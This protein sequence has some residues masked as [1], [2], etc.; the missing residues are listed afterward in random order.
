MK[1]NRIKIFFAAAATVLAVLSCQ[2][3]SEYQPAEPEADNWGIYFPTQENTGSH[4]YDP[5]ME[6]STSFTVARKKSNG[7]VTVP[8]KVTV[9]EDGIFQFGDIVF[10]DG[11]TET[12]LDVS[13]SGAPEGKEV[14]FSLEVVNEGD[15]NYTSVYGSG[16]TGISF[17]VMIVRYEYI[18]NPKTGE[19]AVFTFTQKHWGETAWAYVKY[20]DID[21]VW[22]C[23][24]ETF[25]HEYEGEQYND[26]G[27]F[28][29][30]CGELNFT[31]YTKDLNKEGNAYVQLPPFV[32][33]FNTNYNEDVIGFDYYYYWTVMNPQDQLAGMSWLEFAKKYDGTYPVGY[34]DNNGGLF[35]YITWYYMLVTDG[36]WQ[37]QA[38]DIIG[39]A[40]G[41]T[42]V[43]Y[44]L[45]LETD[46]PQ[47][48]VT[49]VY[50]EAGAD[51]E[52]IQ[53]AVYEG[54]LNAAAVESSADAIIAGTDAS[55][56]LTLEADEV[57]G[58]SYGAF[59]I[60]PEKS[61]KY[62]VV[63]V[64]F[65]SDKAP[66]AVESVTVNHIS[67]GDVEANAVDI[68]VFTEPTPS[69]YSGYTEY[70]S[71]AFGVYGSDITEA[72]IGVYK[73][74]TLPGAL[75]VVKY[76]GG[77]VTESVL[78]QINANGGYYT[79]VGKLD[80]GTEYAVVIWATNGTLDAFA[81][82]VFTTTALPYEWN[83]LGTGLLTDDFMTIYDGIDPITVN[84]SI[85]EEK[86][87]AGLYKVSGFQLALVAAVFDMTEEAMAPYTGNYRFTD[88]L[89]HAENPNAVYIDLQN[90]GVCLNSADGFM[91]I[92]SSVGG[93][94]FS[95]GTLKDGVISFP[96]NG[97]LVG[98][99]DGFYYGNTNGAFKV[100]LPAA[101]SKASS[102]A[103]ASTN[104]I[105]SVSDLKVN[106][107]PV[108]SKETK[109]ERTPQPVQ[110]K[111]VDLAGARKEKQS[112]KKAL[113]VP[114]QRMQ[115]MR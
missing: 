39:I 56:S 30:D 38:Y 35:F 15:T 96:A 112:G 87:N 107:K 94:T 70:D 89:I 28:G 60:A 64:G 75:D 31:I 67:A 59:G 106:A 58:S 4:T 66:Q 54:S 101:A 83:E 108:E 68:S 104:N 7:A 110:V 103:P 76:E 74:S 14:S 27:F 114:A 34:Y 36:G 2:K 8:Y 97:L 43:D 53:Y 50:V 16:A 115:S 3:E 19:P 55:K 63:V 62:T 93:Q 12:T 90:Y 37:Q 47:D 6:R 22:T 1:T 20:Y 91:E 45:S 92:A 73:A 52:Y 86:N 102:V 61:G 65:S 78:S 98:L 95:T 11:Q 111:V 113:S 57:T 99:S 77:A 21:G 17:S 51:I 46:Y 105:G 33:Y 85:A 41:F 81:V 72:H 29:T 49:P 48:G 32:Y 79:V 109:F 26:P 100:V 84:C 25:L 82:D 23:Q 71:F 88:I 24:T 69:R 44:S 40:E 10:A 13:F 42:R 18:L 9:S 5:A 80:P